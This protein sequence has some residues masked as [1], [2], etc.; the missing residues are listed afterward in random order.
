VRQGTAPSTVHQMEWRG[1]QTERLILR[2]WREEDKEPFAA[3]NADPA[4]MEFFPSMLTPD[5]SDELAARFEREQAESG[6]CPWAVELRSS[7]TF[8]GFI[9]LHAVSEMTFSPAVEVGW[10]LAQ[11]FWGQG[12]ATE[13]AMA[14]VRFG[15]DVLDLDEIV[16]FTAVVNQRSRRVMEKLGM[17]HRSEED[18][19]HPRVAPGP[20]RDHVLYRLAR[21]DRRLT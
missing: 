6:F 2:P 9:G 7:S 8:I 1:L 14:A 4:V 16:S 21:G 19:E 12:L 20:L 18:F 10:R 11:P 17:S 5:E 3:M 13:G 15:F